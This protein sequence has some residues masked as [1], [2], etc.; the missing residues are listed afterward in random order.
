MTKAQKAAKKQALIDALNGYEGIQARGSEEFYGRTSP[1]FYMHGLWI[2][3][4]L[5]EW[6]LVNLY[7]TSEEF[8][9]L[10]VLNTLE[11]ILEAHGFYGEPYDGETLMAWPD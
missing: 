9:T 8:Y 5:D 6:P 7:T 4:E 3:G 1:E 11:A 2:T 10:G